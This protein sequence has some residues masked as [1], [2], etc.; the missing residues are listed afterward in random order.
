MLKKI[1]IGLGI[2]I[3]VVIIA[4]VSVP[5]LFKDKIKEVVTETINENLEAVV[6]FD[7]VTLNLF[8]SFPQANVGIQKL[9]I[10]NKAPFKG[11]TLVYVGEVNLKMSIGELFKGKTEPMNIKSIFTKDGFINVHVNKDGIANYDIA[12]KKD[13]EENKEEEDN[14]S[15]LALTIKDY[16]IENYKIQYYDETSKMKFVLDQLNHKGKGDFAAS[17]LDLDTKTTGKVSFDMDGSNYMRNIAISL[18]AVLGLDLEKNIYSFKENK[19]LINQ[20][21]LEF[22]GNIHLV[23][24][25]QEYNLTFKTPTSSF[26]NFLGLIPE[27]YAGSVEKVETTGDFTV[28]GKVNGL[29][30]DTTIPKFNIAID[31]KNSSF[32]YPDL[33]KGIQNIV[34]DTKIINETGLMNDTYVDLNQLSFKIDQDIFNAKATVRNLVENPLVTAS[35]NGIIKL[36]NLTKAYPIQLDKPLTGIL[37]AD[38]TTKFDMKSVEANQYQNIQNSGN[39][40]LSKFQY[41]DETNKAFNINQATVQF[42]TSHIG[43]QELDVTTGKTDMQISGALDNFYGF[44]FKKQ[45][46]KGNFNLKS[47]QFVV[48]DFMS[49]SEPTE[50]KTETKNTAVAN[51]IKIPSFLNCTFTANINTIVYDNLNL[52]NA[53]GR[54]V[55]KNEAVKLENVK[56][57]IFGGQIVANGTVSTKEKTPNFNMDLGMNAVDVTQSFT[58]LEM[59]KSIAP[60][61]N[62]ISGK[63]NSTIKLSGKLDPKELTPDLN[64]LSGDMVGSLQG[65]SIDPSKSKILSLLDTNLKFIDLKKVNLNDQKIHLSFTDGKVNVKPFD[66]KL[67][68][69]NVNVGG[70]HGFDQSM[71]YNLQFD[72]P[73]KHL[74]TEATKLL[75][76]LSPAEANKVNSVPITATVT[77]SF[78][79]PKIGTDLQKA[80][81]NLATQLV[82]QQKDKLISQ[83]TNAL[84]NLLSG[85]KTAADSTKTTATPKE[86][87]KEKAVDALK[88]LFGKKK[89]E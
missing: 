82:Q 79:N 2:F 63:L 67:Q 55:I 75:S 80:V 61:A 11:D 3:L 74:G 53:S 6:A 66:L 84:E 87:A 76:S 10:I 17:V 59:L 7:D 4:L 22:D 19:A 72:V 45:E 51:T 37:K 68:D 89:K 65:T 29:L 24:A 16:A 35:F 40:S 20:L 78:S 38:I 77:G 13:E 49:A 30:S 83:G 46:L 56:T 26:K 62:I 86:E 50:T 32:K 5:F 28:A 71:N 33:P 81:S 60:I 41:V 54:M 88:G 8:K 52:K 48:T 25:G 23:D 43:L 21:P 42:N 9:S 14:S 34:I 69:I 73:A 85:H 39:L 64:T 57:D 36:E 27:E 18:D 47:N 1:L 12:I 31:S 70:Q 58:Q 15:P 44:L